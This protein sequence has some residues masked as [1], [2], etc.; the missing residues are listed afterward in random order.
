MLK[1]ACYCIVLTAAT[2]LWS[3]VEPAASG[4]GFD[5]DDTR[6]MTPPPVSRDAYPIVVGVESRSNYLDGGLAF[7][8]AY[9]DNL[10]GVDTGAPVSDETYAFMPTVNIDRR[11][12]K[13]GESLQYS[14]GFNLYQ[15]TSELNGISQNGTADYRFHISPYAV[16]VLSDTFWQNSNLYNQTNPFVGGGVSTGGSSNS[17]LIAPF[18]NQLQNSSNAG[19][20]YQYGKNA[21]IGG[22]GTYTFSNFSNESNSQG[23]SDANLAGFGAFYSRRIAR[24]QYIGVTYQFEKF[25]THPIDTYTQTHTVLGFYTHYFTKNFS[26]SILAGPQQYASWSPTI[27]KQG[28]WIPAVQGSFGLQTLRTNLAVSFTHNVSGAP[29]F[30]GAYHANM[31]SLSGRFLFARMWSVGASGDYSLLEPVGSDPA[32][33]GTGGHTITG[34]VDV[35]HTVTERLTAAAGYQHFHESYSNIPA[36]STFPNSNRVYLSVSYGFHRPLGR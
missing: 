8:A 22:S 18:A 34:G 29:G 19:I 13:Q 16:I 31:A 1:I 2:S 3:Q 14:A 27:E 20:N 4:G 9:V 35:Q 24:S 21:M 10:L 25:V 33:Y 7:T 5:L 30:I 12:P 36:V 23:L 26:F 32:A 17:V 6:M 11:S 28:H 15:H